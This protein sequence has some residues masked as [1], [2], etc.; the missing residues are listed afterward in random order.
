MA[1]IMSYKTKKNQIRLKN[2]ITK[3]SDN[4][5]RLQPSFFVFITSRPWPRPTAA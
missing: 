4:L 2:K 3:L 5:G 1:V